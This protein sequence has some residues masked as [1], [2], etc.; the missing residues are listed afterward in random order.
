MEFRGSGPPTRQVSQR[1]AQGRP[2]AKNF[3]GWCQVSP[4]RGGLQQDGKQVEEARSGPPGVPTVDGTGRFHVHRQE[5]IDHRHGEE[6]R[7]RQSEKEDENEKGEGG[8]GIKV[9]KEGE[10]NRQI[11][12]EG[13]INRERKVSNESSGQERRDDYS[14]KER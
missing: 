13:Q 12:E 4:N 11:K 10:R 1:K 3:A 7:N 14:S 8:R 2:R 9:E 5:I 6:T